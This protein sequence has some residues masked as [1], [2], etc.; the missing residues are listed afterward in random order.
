MPKTGISYF[1]NRNPRH[2]VID[3]EEIVS[4]HCN[5]IVHCF[6]ENDQ[7]FYKNTMSDLIELSK[8]ADL[9]V[10]LLPWGLGRA[11][12]G[13]AFSH[14]ALDNYSGNQRYE[15]GEYAPAACPN[16]PRFVDFIIA[17]I[18]DAARMGADALCWKEPHFY[19]IYEFGSLK[20]MAC[21]C[22][23][24]QRKYRVFYGEKFPSEPNEHLHQFREDAMI[25]F[26]ATLCSYAKMK[27]LRNSICLPPDKAD[28]SGIINL[29]KLA[30]IPELDTLAANP[31]WIFLNKDLKF[32]ATSA[33]RIVQISK[34]YEIEPMLWVQN[35]KIP[36]DRGA[37][38]LEA[39]A[40]SYAEGL[41]NFAAWSYYGTEYM[42]YIKCD[43]PKSVWDQLGEIYGK[44]QS[45][46]WE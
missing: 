14:Y 38:I 1:G 20:K 5:Y 13:E 36:H 12:A 7:L 26:L 21:F 25:D 28:A 24:C 43:H 40:I 22:E 41:R 31:Y 30:R 9:E 45:G 39:I 8:G 23:N 3:L 37:E 10:H 44:I 42:S 15:T 35:F 11:F 46:E 4:H 16:D 18:D 2:F 33:K 6:S 34:K 19:N 32:V 29:E 27:G 17:W